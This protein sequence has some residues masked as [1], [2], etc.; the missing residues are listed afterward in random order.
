[1]QDAQATL[2]QINAL[3]AEAFR[4]AQS[5]RDAEAESLWVRIL[6]IDPN[7]ARGGGVILSVEEQEFDSRGCPR[8]QT[9]VDA[10][11]Y[12]GGAEG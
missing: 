2:Q 7:H 12:D 5:G 3:E 11:V 9:E 10:A 1:M 4:A 8:E 6:E